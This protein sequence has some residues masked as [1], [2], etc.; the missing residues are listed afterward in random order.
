MTL[1]NFV[2]FLTMLIWALIKLF[3]SMI[4]CFVVFAIC[5]GMLVAIA[6]LAHKSTKDR[7]SVWAEIE[8]MEKQEYGDDT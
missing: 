3:S 8:E 4:L 7:Y 6:E 1:I 2:N 5:W